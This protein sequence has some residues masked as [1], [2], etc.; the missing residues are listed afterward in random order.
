MN[1]LRLFFLPFVPLYALV[2]WVRNRLFDAHIL[3]SQKPKIPTICI[4][5]I[6]VGGSGKTPHI[7]YLIRLL[8]DEFRVCTLSRGYGR[9]SKGFVLAKEPVSAALLGDESM[10]FFQ[11]FPDIAVCVDANRREAI[12]K[13]KIEAPNTEVILLDDAFQHRYVTPG[14]TVLLTDYFR[15]YY[16]DYLLP[17]GNLREPRNAVKRT[18]IIV[19]TKCPSMLSPIVKQDILEKIK[20]SQNQTVYFSYLKHGDLRHLNGSVCDINKDVY[21][22]FVVLAGVYNP[23]PLVDHLRNLTKDIKL[24]QFP[25]HHEFTK[26]DLKRVRSHFLDYFCNHK[27]IVTTEKDLMRLKDSPAFSEISDLPICYVPIEVEFHK[28]DKTSFDTQVLEFVQK[29]RQDVR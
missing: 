19:V 10:Q 3:R 22:H 12:R 28:D 1:P 2:I 4:G 17:V 15:P 23:Y 29:K 6:C 16:T 20:P 26:S 27:Y 14:L 11:K 18:D 9:K 5:N 21:N 7:E 8:K 24:F 25:D 13:L